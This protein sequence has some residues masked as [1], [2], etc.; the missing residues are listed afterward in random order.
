MYYSH[1][2]A[3]TEEEKSV[4]GVSKSTFAMHKK[5]LDSI[6]EKDEVDA[7]EW[8]PRRPKDSIIKEVD[9]KAIE[10]LPANIRNLFN[11]R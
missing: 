10:R 11:L 5:Q 1:T 8:A 3:P 4:I 7:E 2:V 6:Q 9:P